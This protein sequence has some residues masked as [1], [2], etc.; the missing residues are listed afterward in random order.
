MLRRTGEERQILKLI[1]L[2]KQNWFGHWTRRSVGCV[3]M[4]T[5]ERIVNGRKYRGQ[6]R[7]QMVNII[8]IMGNM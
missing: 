6:R 4:D 3:L 5:T 7:Y 8:K 2:Q 1:R